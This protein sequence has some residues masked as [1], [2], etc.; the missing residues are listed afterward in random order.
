MDESSQL[1]KSANDQE[2]CLFKRIQQ[3]EAEKESSELRLSQLQT[4]QAQVACD[5][6]VFENKL[7][8]LQTT[9]LE[10]HSACEQVFCVLIALSVYVILIQLCYAP[11]D[12]SR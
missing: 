9:Q 4:D 5:R 7:T 3:L 6:I 2:A 1:L 8:A 10:L 11:G 12:C